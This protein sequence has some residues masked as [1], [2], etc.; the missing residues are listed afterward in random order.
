MADAY[1]GLTIRFGGDT[2]KLTAALRS[3]TRAAQQTQT[4]LRAVTKAM[5]FDPQSINNVSLK[6]RLMEERSESLAS[7]LKTTTTAYKQLGNTKAEGMTKSVR[8]L[9]EETGNAALA[10]Q[11]ALERYNKVDAELERMYV[12]INK[13]ARASEELDDSFDLRKADNIEEAAA[14]LVR[15]GVITQD[16]ADELEFLRMVWTD[17]FNGN[18]A[19]KQVQTFRELEVKANGLQSE[20]KSLSREMAELKVPSNLSTR[21]DDARESV[22]RIDSALKALEGEIKRCD[23][24][25]KLD[26]SNTAAA[27]QKMDAL[28]TASDLALRKAAILGRQLDSYKASGADILASRM[29]SVALEAAEAN[30][31]YVDIHASLSRAKGELETFRAA[32]QRL[33][34]SVE[35]TDKDYKE[36]AAAIKEAEAEVRELEA[37]ERKANDRREEANMAAE[38]QELS[39]QISSAKAQAAGFAD[40]MQRSGQTSAFTWSNVKSLGMTLS[41]VLTPAMQMVGEYGMQS[42]VDIDTAYRDMRKTVQGSESDFESLKQAAL[43]FSSQNFTSAEQILQIQA[44]GGEL[45]ILTEDLEVFSETVSNLDI[46]TNLNAEE[47]ATTLGSLSNILNDLDSATMPKFADSLVRLGNN[48]ASTESQIADIAKRIGSMGSIV[49][50]T[51]PDILAWASTIASTGQNAEAAGTAI[52]KTMSNIETAVAKGG[53]SLQGFADVAGMSAQQ[54]AETWNSNPTAALQAFIEGLRNVEQNGG[55]ADKTLQDLG[56]NAVRQKQAIEGLMQSIGGLDSNLKMSRD[57]WNGVSDEWGAAGDAAREA[58]AKNEG[59]AGSLQR[60]KN[61]ASNAGS[62]IGDA[63][64]PMFADLADVAADAGKAF[65][66]SSDGFKRLVAG[67]GVFLAVMGPGLSVISSSMIGIKKLKEHL[68]SGGSAWAKLAKSAAAAKDALNGA[69][70]AGEV[71]AVSFSGLTRAQ[72]LATAGSKLLTVGMGALKAGA[73]GLAVAGIGLVVK[74]LIEEH[75]HQRLVNDATKSASA[76]MSEAGRSAQ[77]MGDNLSTAEADVEGLL[78]SMKSLNEEATSLLSETFA[79]NAT[80]DRHVATINELANKSELSAMQQE[81]L[82]QAVQGYNEITG[83]NI[84]VIDAASGKLSDQNGQLIT[85]TDLI[86]QSAEAWKNRAKQEAYTKLTAQYLQEQVKA[87]AELNIANGKLAASQDD[88]NRAVMDYNSANLR[89]DHL[90]MREAGKQMTD[91]Q[92][93][94]AKYKGEIE[95]L[96][97]AYNS[98]K[99]QANRFSV[100]S[101]LAVSNLSEGVKSNISSLSPAWQMFAADIAMSLQ[102]SGQNVGTFEQNLSAMGLSIESVKAIGEENFSLLYEACNGNLEMMKWSIENYNSVPIINKDGSVNINDASL[103]DAQGNLYTWNGSE[104]VDQNGNAVIDDTSLQDAQGRAYTWNKGRLLDKGAK[105]DLGHKS[106]KEAQD[107]MDKANKTKL[108]NHDAKSDIDSS[109][110]KLDIDRTKKRKDNPPKDQRATTTI[111]RYERTYKSTSTVPSGSGGR[112]RMAAQVPMLAA[113]SP[114]AYQAV[115]ARSFAATAAVASKAAAAA[116]VERFAAGID[117]ERNVG[118]YTYDNSKTTTYEIHIDGKSME[119][120]GE[121]KDS[122]KRLVKAVSRYYR[123]N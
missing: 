88:F 84:S 105:A 76:I 106:V 104:L 77:S 38:Y 33:M 92:A 32:Q 118:N 101:M 79:N 31:S 15:L 26:P 80:L 56:I 30:A 122:A 9:S 94:M 44:I 47:A 97:V 16:T 115:A 82:R 12:A 90:G 109:S 121:V 67:A 99:E 49:G 53:D 50:M 18:E 2:S 23:A 78:Q 55:S 112:T 39:G 63:V 89:G 65:A 69:G 93:K 70:T 46:A 117:K 62:E 8:E 21:F 57:A 43:D 29:R 42:A 59:L 103:I 114:M 1:R 68:D 96:A 35:A 5:R 45:G 6:L 60:L 116:N 52:S 123:M 28:A 102:A 19:A 37:A 40:Q 110:V 81:R 54:F 24:A 51:T 87:E 66:E 91:A 36:V 10:A 14:E 71:A 75:R 25:L 85:N 83:E 22:K 107:A 100:E 27:A 58:E 119:A 64:A 13:A 34:D 20:M 120:G 72:K 113:A 73:V 48:G 61:I 108:R 11:R 17:A 74:N 111:T 95:D 3:A 7:Q 98:S 41:A 86:N 4:Q